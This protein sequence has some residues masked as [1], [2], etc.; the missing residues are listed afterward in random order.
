MSVDNYTGRPGAVTYWPIL[1]LDRAEPFLL[2][3]MFPAEQ[4][5]L[6]WAHFGEVMIGRAAGRLF[7]TTVLHPQTL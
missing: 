6:D 1:C 5:Q 3:P 2:L 7:P 4:A